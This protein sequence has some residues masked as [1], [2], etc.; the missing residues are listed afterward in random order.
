VIALAK[1]AGLD[2]APGDAVVVDQ[3]G[4]LA[5]LEQLAGQRIQPDGYA[6]LPEPLQIG[7]GCHGHS[8]AQL[9]ARG[10]PASTPSEVAR[11]GQSSHLDGPARVGHR[12]DVLVSP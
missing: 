7:I 12:L 4:E 10:S 3:P 6:S 5:G 8:F 2:V 1:M 11:I 9:S